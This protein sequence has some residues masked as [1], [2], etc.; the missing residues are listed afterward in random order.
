[1]RRLI[2]IWDLCCLQKPVIIVCGCERVNWNHVLFSD[3]HTKCMINLQQMRLPTSQPG[4]RFK[5]LYSSISRR[6]RKRNIACYFIPSYYSHFTACS[7]SV[8]ASDILFTSSLTWDWNSPREKWLLQVFF[9]FCRGNI[10]QGAVTLSECF[11]SCLEKGLLYRERIYSTCEVNFGRWG[12]QNTLTKLIEIFTVWLTHLRRVDSSTI[13]LWII[14]F[15]TAGCKVS[16]HH[17]YVL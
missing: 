3:V 4:I 9:F 5:A 10:L 16:F 1:M 12:L 15:P 7:S 13:T 6:Q 17:Y 14:L 8:H 11:V 2:M